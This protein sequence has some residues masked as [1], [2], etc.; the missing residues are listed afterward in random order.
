MKQINEII[1]RMIERAIVNTGFNHVS[2]DHNECQEIFQR[3]P[4]WIPFC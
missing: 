3:V 2:I 4:K 1:H